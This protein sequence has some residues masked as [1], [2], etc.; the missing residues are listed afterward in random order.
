MKTYKY[1]ADGGTIRVEHGGF[2]CHF[3]NGIG[4]G[5][6]NISIISKKDTH[7]INKIEWEFIECFEVAEGEVATLMEYDSGFGNDVLHTFKVGI[8]PVYRK[9]QPES[10][11][12]RQVNGDMIIGKWS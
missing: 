6:Y 7:N 10:M 9:A 11:S 5:T 8:Y 1:T 12:F 2:A 4:D 3:H